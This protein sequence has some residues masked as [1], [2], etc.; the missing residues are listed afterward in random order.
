MVLLK[1]LDLAHDRGIRHSPMAKSGL[2]SV[3]A[4]EIVQLIISLV[5]IVSLLAKVGRSRHREG[6]G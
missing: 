2:G 4:G 5:A 1:Y 3:G 6:G